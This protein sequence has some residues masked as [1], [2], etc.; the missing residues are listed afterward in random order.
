MPRGSTLQGRFTLGGVF[1]ILGAFR[2]ELGDVFT[3]ALNVLL[4]AA[5]LQISNIQTVGGEMGRLCQPMLIY[6]INVWLMPTI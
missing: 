2:V 4:L 1:R 3:V 6:A 5:Q